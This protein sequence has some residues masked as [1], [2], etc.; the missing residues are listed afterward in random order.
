M[1]FSTSDTLAENPCRL[2]VVEAELHDPLLRTRGH[3]MS[4]Y[5]H[6]I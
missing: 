5:P 1:R 4:R 2:L 3:K 6:A